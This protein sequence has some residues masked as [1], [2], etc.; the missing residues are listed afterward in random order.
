MGLG[1]ERHALTPLPPRKRLG[2]HCIRDW[3]GPRASLDGRG[4]SRS[5]RDSIPITSSPSR[6]SILTTLSR[7]HYYYPSFCNAVLWCNYNKYT[8][9]TALSLYFLIVS[10]LRR[11][12]VT[13]LLAI[14]TC[15]SNYY[16]EKHECR[17]S[18]SLLI[19]EVR[20]PIFVLKV[21]IRVKLNLSV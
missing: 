12:S 20:D 5:Y 9:Y 7:P 2:T 10:S 11:V 6:I 16:R 17:L 13:F 19:N 21:R 8:T 1:G 3:V 18:C 14:F 4:K 15:F